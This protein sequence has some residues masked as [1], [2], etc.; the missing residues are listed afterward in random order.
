MSENSAGFV[1]EVCD[2]KQLSLE[3]A[4]EFM[5]PAA[6]VAVSEYSIPLDG[7]ISLNLSDFTARRRYTDAVEKFGLDLMKQCAGR[8]TVLQSQMMGIDSVWGESSAIIGSLAQLKDEM[9]ALDP[10]EVDFSPKKGLAKLFNPINAYFDQYTKAEPAINTIVK[11][12]ETGRSILKN[13]NTSLEIEESN[14]RELTGKLAIA[15]QEG[16]KIVSALDKLVLS[17]SLN[18]DLRRFVNDELAEPMRMRTYDL[19]QL[20]AVNRQGIVTFEVLRR[21]NKELIRGIDRASTVTLTALKTA[22]MVASSLYNQ[23]LVLKK[24]EALD[25]SADGLIKGTSAMLRQSGA[26]SQLAQSSGGALSC[27]TLKKAFDD[28]FD[29]LEVIGNY[30]TQALSGMHEAAD[31]FSAMAQENQSRLAAIE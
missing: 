25:K 27:E 13:D 7:L 18:D 9:R 14:L 5:P 16:E 31:R 23:K 28:A 30:K 4:K 26:V 24:I 20:T 19:H 10:S 2:T 12:L 8:G 22:V 17:G 11:S 15:A 29:T 6:P 1:L 3:V 21:N